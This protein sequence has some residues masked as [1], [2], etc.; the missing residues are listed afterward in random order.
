M[1]NKKINNM[2]LSVDP[3]IQELLKI[4][5]KKRKVSVSKLVRDIVEKHLSPTEQQEHEDID[6]VIFKIPN[7]VKATEEELRSW[8]NPRVEGIVRALTSSAK[9]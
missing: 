3:E 1:T 4:V 5:A 9:K 2:S 7:S 8:L 6:T